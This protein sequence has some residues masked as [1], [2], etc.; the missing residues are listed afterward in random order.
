MISDEFM[1]KTVATHKLMMTVKNYLDDVMMKVMLKLIMINNH[2][3]GNDKLKS[4]LGDGLPVDAGCINR[5]AA[6]HVPFWHN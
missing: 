5:F 3:N 2:E 6:H 4:P 1:I